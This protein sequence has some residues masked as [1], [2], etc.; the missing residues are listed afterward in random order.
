VAIEALI[1]A[2]V[3]TF[4]EE[5]VRLRP[6]GTVRAGGGLHRLQLGDGPSA[7][8]LEVAEPGAWALFTQH[9]PAEFGLAVEAGGRGVGPAHEREFAP[10]HVHDGSVT[11]VGI[12]LPGDLDQRRLNEWL[13]TLLQTQGPDIFRMKGVLS[14]AGERRRFVFQ[15]IHMLFDGRPDRP[16]GAEPRQNRLI[17]IGRNLDRAALTDGFRTCLVAAS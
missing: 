14:I 15:G 3:P 1:G 5:P 13:G 10:D 7:Y 6:G 9:L 11:S 4:S 16:W 2:T 17:F 8:A 12:T